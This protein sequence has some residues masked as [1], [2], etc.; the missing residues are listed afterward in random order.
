MLGSS[1][2][3]L[4]SDLEVE[5]KPDA[6]L[7]AMT[8]YGIGG[9]ADL[10]IRPRRIEALATLVKRC[11]RSGVP[12]HVFGRGANLLIADEG[13]GGIVARLDQPA[14]LRRRYRTSGEDHLLLA[15]A[16]ADLAK[17][18]MDAARR[19]LEGL[20]HL[21]GIPATIG[22]AVRMNAGG[23]LGCIGD[24]VES[25]TCLTRSGQRVMYPAGELKFGYRESNIPD[26]IILAAS[27]RLRPDDPIALRRRIKEVFEHKKSTQPLA[28]HS[29][30]CVF[31]NPI[32]P[33]SEQRVSAGKLID[34]AGLKNLRI[35]G[36]AVSS[37]HA[38]FIITEPGAT[39]GDVIQL[40]DKIRRRVFEH[41][42]IQLED[43]LV[44]W[45]R[46][47]EEEEE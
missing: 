29:A 13:V 47:E 19:G 7:G 14:F 27:L 38:N 36:A 20:S 25:V 40:M 42:G 8:W 39:A 23:T 45:R 15:G 1:S 5:V 10:L 17:T 22:G 26:P 21:A 43:E 37:R 44:I 34:Q 18:L 24:A 46:G 31:K 12:L 35:G 9:R 3:S 4:F 16:G 6:P 41:C 11:H 32:D 33:V 2:S 30:G 28:E